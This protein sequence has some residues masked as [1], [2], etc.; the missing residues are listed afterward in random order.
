MRTEETAS[1]GLSWAIAA[2][3]GYESEMPW[4]RMSVWTLTAGACATAGGA[5][6][7]RTSGATSPRATEATGGCGDMAAPGVGY[8]AGKRARK[9][10]QTVEAAPAN[11][12]GSTF[13]GADR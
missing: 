3:G 13:P 8:G 5:A 1:L 10:D 9:P 7:S 4:Y 2:L 12:P 6:T 11:R